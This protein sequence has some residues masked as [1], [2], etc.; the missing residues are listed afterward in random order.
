MSKADYVRAQSQTR[1]HHC[2]WPGCERPV[3]PSMWGCKPH[4]F[5][6]PGALRSRIWATYKVGQ[7]VNGTPSDEYIEA[8]KA[9]QA[10]IAVYQAAPAA[11]QE[12]TP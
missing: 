11:T 1:K 4:W 7:E 9:V 10:W 2:H 6:L 3:P 8:A 12:P 5:T